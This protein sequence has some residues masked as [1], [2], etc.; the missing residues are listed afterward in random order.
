MSWALFSSI[1]GGK[2]LAQAIR[3]ILQTLHDTPSAQ[4]DLQ[5]MCFAFTDASIADELVG[6][7]RARPDIQVRVVADWSQSAAG[8]PTVLQRILSLGLPNFHLRYKIDLPYDWDPER[9]R[10]IYSYAHST[11]MLHHKTLN[12]RHNGRSDMVVT[13]SFNWSNRGQD[14]YENI[15]V[16]DNRPDYDALRD[17]FDAE[18]QALWSDDS[19]TAAPERARAIFDRLR[20]S[21]AEGMDFNDLSVL[22]D[23]LVLPQPS[24]TSDTPAPRR[25]VE[26]PAIV[27]FSGGYALSPKESAGH[28]S[29]ND[30]RKLDLL[31]A[32]AVRRP[33]PLTLNTL[34][35]EAIR[36]VPDGAQINVAMYALSNRVPEFQDLL[37][38]AKRGCRLRLLLDR[39]INA[40]GI[41]RLEA[42]AEDSGLPIEIRSTRRR[43]HQKYICCPETGMVLT[44]TAN[45][46]LDATMRHADHRILL[47]HAPELAAEFSADFETIWQRVSQGVGQKRAA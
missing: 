47:R 29:V 20:K 31:R 13:G 40:R 28:A 16:F 1:D 11:G 24:D 25:L 45:M 32:S 22:A 37:A 19:L 15:L 23:T 6:L 38:A 18:F 2:S 21:V 44:G 36:S 39:K 41:A 10:L 14:A 43:M 12:L 35:M 26:G 17:A 34:T 30:R 8:S 46:T 7:M 27:A 5:I 42:L 33:A 3:V 9:R 4:T